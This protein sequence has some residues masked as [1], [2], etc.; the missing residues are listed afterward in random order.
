[1]KA[2]SAEAT[3]PC[4]VDLAGGGLDVWPVYLFYP[5]AVT[6]NVAVDRR[7]WCRVE[8]GGE[9]VQIESKD[10]LLKASAARVDE[11]VADGALALVAHVLRSLEVESGVRVVTQ[12]RVPEGSGLG[13]SSAV[14][15]AVAAAVNAVLG[16]AIDPDR[17]WP[18][19]RDAQARCLG[20]PTGPRDYQ[21]A[22]RGGTLALHLEP[23][24][25]RV[26][27]LA[28][29]PARVEESLLLVDSEAEGPSGPSDWEFV[30]GQIDGD[31]RVRGALEALA[32]AARGIRTAL[33]EG[34]FEDV[35]DLFAEEW[36]A[37]KRL[38]PGVTTPEIDRVAEVARAAGG[39]AKPCG[40][41]GGR[42]VAVW[43]PPGARGPGRREAVQEALTT[44]GFRIF[45]AGV[46][47]RGLEVA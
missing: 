44:A 45:P 39:A 19:L 21:P 13:G 27:P 32:A 29:D 40:A 2:D 22:L 11:L 8:L 34:R 9:G 23:G 4:R 33:V 36:E 14:A 46:D 25:V 6:V 42:V 17:L 38:A 7:A 20:R 26:E 28:V 24:Q 18:L 15:V 43:A 47:L 12:S 10:T 31:D 16:R 37:R 3:A 41:G 30:K 1:M 5:G 35:V